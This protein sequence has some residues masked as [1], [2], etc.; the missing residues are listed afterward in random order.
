MKNNDDYGNSFSVCFNMLKMRYMEYDKTIDDSGFICPDDKV[1]VFIS[2]ETILSNLSRV[3]DIDKKLILEREFPTILTA[4]TLNIMAHYKRFFRK[5][6]LETRVFIYYSDLQS[7]LFNNEKYVDDYR[8]YYLNKFMSNPRYSYLGDT[9]VNTILPDV[10]TIS[11]FIPNVYFIKATNIEG[12]LIPLIISQIDTSYR[13]FII[14]GDIYD[15]Q[16]QYDNNF[17]V[18]Y[19]RKNNSGSSIT[20]DIKKTISV[21]LKEQ[22][23][24]DI[25][26]FIYKNKQFYY[27][28]LCSNGNKVRCIEPI[29]GIGYKSVIK[30]IEN[31]ISNGIITEN[32]EHI[33]LLMKIFPED[34][35]K[36][37]LNNY[38]AVNIYEQ[39]KELSNV[40][41]YNIQKQ[42]IDRF[43]NNSLLT[44][45]STKFYH[46]PLM[47]QELTC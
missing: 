23:E 39:Y 42:L 22:N 10:I 31:G 33:E 2:Y 41:I 20:T 15:T 6:G 7:N 27:L 34:I 13:N 14:T 29:K 8:S 25:P 17:F 44:L 21:I 36:K 16:Y 47:L 43:D 24:N 30:Y 4:E 37:I 28:M 32:T 1:N 3:K 19:V 38:L 12:S 45:N 5:N 18:H 9:L 26:E 35:Q 40:D 46:H 11:Q